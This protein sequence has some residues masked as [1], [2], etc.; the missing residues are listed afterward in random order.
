MISIRSG[1]WLLG[2]SLIFLSLGAL[3][4]GMHFSQYYNA[5]LLLNPANTALMPDN[6]YRVGVN[7]RKQWS[8]IPVPYKTISAFADFQALRNKNLTN[9]LGFGL[10][11]WNDKAGDGDLSLTRVEGLL[12][13]HLQ[14]GEYNM[15]SVGASA[16]SVQR[17]VDFN[18][19]TFDRQ[20]DGF[21]FN[22]T[23]PTGE[24]GYTM[25]TSFFDLAAGIN[26][27]FFPNENV[28]LKVG[29]GMAHLTQPRESFYN[30]Q[31]RLGLRPTANIDL[32]LK[33]SSAVILNPSAY[34]TTQKSASELVYGTLFKVNMSGSNE[35]STQLILGGFHRWSEA[36]VGT[37]GIEY[38][39]WRLMTSYDFTISKLSPVNKGKGA[40]EL[41]ILYESVY[42]DFS[43]TRRT[44]NCPRF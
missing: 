17:S 10:A 20:W 19:L 23:K 34:Y 27:A 15:L 24:L 7:Y 26:Y 3:S 16:A 31:N 39:Q 25:K 21:G 44:Y 43:R 37:I 4:Q 5:P 22:T 32:L 11:F 9:W 35:V 29:L 28:Y 14:F 33:L 1:K 8:S 36:V 41:S 40:F 2:I 18:K 30:Q 13:Y 6:D 38:N 12:A 42:G